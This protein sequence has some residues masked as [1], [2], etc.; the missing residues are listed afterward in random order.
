M[1]A[2]LGKIRDEYEGAL[3]HNTGTLVTVESTL[4]QLTWFLPGRFSDSEVASEG[5]EY[6]FSHIREDYSSAIPSFVAVY[7]ALS[8][9]TIYHDTIL[10]KRIARV[11]EEERKSPFPSDQLKQEE[12]KERQHLQAEGADGSN[13]HSNG[14]TN[15]T[16]PKAAASNGFPAHMPDTKSDTTAARE[17]I[18]P[19]ASDHYRFT[20]H[21]A[22]N[23]NV[24]RHASRALAVVGYVQLLLE[25]LVRKRSGDGKRWRLVVVLEAFK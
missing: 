1:A 16:A 2:L 15:G 23:S 14:C 18:L 13:G 21:F 22:A 17:T 12:Q 8:L 3:L 9:L 6:R 7:S 5:S 10:Q 20:R 25:M 19:P 4:R 24:Y 11:R